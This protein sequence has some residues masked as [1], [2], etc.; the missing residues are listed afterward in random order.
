MK[1]KRW[2][3]GGQKR[4]KEADMSL[5]V[6]VRVPVQILPVVDPLF[7]VMAAALMRCEVTLK[8]IHLIRHL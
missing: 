3:E 1:R 7:G 8:L 4:R 2:R 5:Y 6:A